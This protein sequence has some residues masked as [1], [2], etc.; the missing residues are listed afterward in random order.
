MGL[1][2][3]KSATLYNQTNDN[4]YT[5]TFQRVVAPSASKAWRFS[6]RFEV[7]KAVKITIAV[8]WT[9]TSYRFYK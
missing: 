2:P 1:G 8:F 6:I 3:H 7:F 4:I 9:V 5:F